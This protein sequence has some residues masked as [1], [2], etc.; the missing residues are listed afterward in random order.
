MFGVPVGR[1]SR[2]FTNYSYEII[3]IEGLS[4]VFLEKDLDGDLATPNPILETPLPTDPTLPVLD[5]FFFGEE[6]R[7][8][9][10]KLTPSFVHNTVD[11]PYTP[12]SGRKL[13][14]TPQLA[15]GILGGTVNFLKPDVEL[16]L[17]IPHTRRT[18]LG[19]RAEAAMII[20]YG[21]TKLL[22]LYQ[23]FFLGGETQIRGV[24]IRTVGPITESRALGGQ[25][26]RPLQRRVLL[27]HRGAAARSP[28]LRRRAGVPRGRQHR[29]PA[30]P[31]LDGRGDAVHHAR[32]ERPLPAHLRVEPEP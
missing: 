20:P 12:R 32:P 11:N 18:S 4:G 21:S 15:G 23:R 9:E 13:A 16:I 10:S 22:P 24:P 14:L 5:P 6:G 30:V 31:H 17:Y 1:F 3:N 27:R 2:F 25:Q 29:P 28:L 26:V 19:I 8:R 7:R